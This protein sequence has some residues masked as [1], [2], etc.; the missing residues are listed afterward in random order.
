MS[1]TSGGHASPPAAS[2][3]V[4]TFHTHFHPPESHSRGL[5]DSPD[6]HVRRTREPRRVATTERASTPASAST[7]HGP[8]GHADQATD[9]THQRVGALP[10]RKTRTPRPTSI[11]KS[12][13]LRP[14]CQATPP[15]STDSR[16]CRAGNAG[17]GVNSSMGVSAGKARTESS[18][19]PGGRVQGGSLSPVSPVGR[20][21]SRPA[22]PREGLD[23]RHPRPAAAR[24][25]KGSA[26]WARH[27][28]GP[29]GQEHGLASSAERACVCAPVVFFK[30]TGD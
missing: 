22:S 11:R 13:V 12:P 14:A 8:N 17:V 2:R 24:A 10:S 7:A 25:V 23:A 3:P 1:P 29:L 21:W 16:Y 5:K 4:A 30:S 18:L 27:A 6:T 20:G 26:L 19:Q 9:P 15:S 28:P